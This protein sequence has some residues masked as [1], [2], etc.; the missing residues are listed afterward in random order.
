M[1]LENLVRSMRFTPGGFEKG[2]VHA[3]SLVF[4][5]FIRCHEV[6]ITT[7]LFVQDQTVPNS[8]E[9]TRFENPEPQYVV[10]SSKDYENVSIAYSEPQKL[11]LIQRIR[12]SLILV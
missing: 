3:D 5:G 2:E 7:M 12:I 1:D 11:N 10:E 6:K 8:T 4:L 9:I